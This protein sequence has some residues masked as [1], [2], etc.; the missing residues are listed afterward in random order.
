MR[1]LVLQPCGVSDPCLPRSSRQGGV[2]PRRSPEPGASVDAWFGV[3]DLGGGRG[4]V[5]GLLGVD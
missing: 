1:L 2:V 5:R 4:G 3:G